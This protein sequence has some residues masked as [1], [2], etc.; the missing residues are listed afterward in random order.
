MPNDNIR[1]KVGEKVKLF[2]QQGLTETEAV[3]KAIQEVSKKKRG[4]KL[5]LLRAASN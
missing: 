1:Q 2:M 5:G 3:A 4:K